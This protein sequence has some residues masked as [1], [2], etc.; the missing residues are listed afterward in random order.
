MVIDTV[1][2]LAQHHSGVTA[3]FTGIIDAGGSP[4]N[5]AQAQIQNRIDKFKTALRELKISEF[6]EALGK[7]RDQIEAAGQE[8]Q[9]PVR[10]RLS[11]LLSELRDSLDTYFHD[12][13]RPNAFAV[14]VVVHRLDAAIEAARE[15][16]EELEDRLGA[17]NAVP[18]G[19]GALDLTLSGQQSFATVVSKLSSLDSLYSELCGFQRLSPSDSPLG[20]IR[21]EADCLW[22][23]VF[24]D[25][26]V[27]D[28]LEKLILLVGKYFHRKYTTEGKITGLKD[29]AATVQYVATVV[30]EVCLEGPHKQAAQEDVSRGAEAIAKQLRI[31]LEGEPEVVVNGTVQPILSRSDSPRLARGERLML[32]S[33]EEL[34]SASD[35]EGDGTEKQV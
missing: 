2:S 5:Q 13:V 31:L 10:E 29:H 34:D 9:P 17:G 25:T 1:G 6:F 15:V 28:R 35:G 32:E 27:M 26:K 12:Q 19:R 23:W 22:V 11:T 4:L 8:S 33:G 16:C 3:A 21:L 14:L 7:L 18:S 24:G 30:R 20:I